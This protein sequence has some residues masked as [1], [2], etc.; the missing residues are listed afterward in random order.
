LKSLREEPAPDRDAW[1]KS[2]RE[3]ALR[4]GYEEP[5]PLVFRRGAAG[6][7]HA[8]ARKHEVAARW[9]DG[10]GA[11]EA[12]AFGGWP[13]NRRFLEAR[14]DDL[15]G[16]GVPGSG[17]LALAGAM[18]CGLLAWI[19]A[20]AV[21]FIFTVPLC[22]EAKS[23]WAAK[24]VMFEQR[25]ETSRAP[26]ASRVNAAPVAPA[27]FIPAAALAFFVAIPLCLVFALGEL[28]PAIS[29]WNLPALLTACIVFPMAL[30]SPGVAL[31]GL[32]AGVLTP[33]A[34]WA[35]YAGLRALLGSGR[36]PDRGK[37]WT[38]GIATAVVAAGIPALM[39]QGSDVYKGIRDR[40]LF[41]TRTGE[42][43]ATF[44]YRNTPLS[45]FALRPPEL[46]PRNSLLFAGPVP[47]GFPVTEY[48]FIVSVCSTKADFLKLA[49]GRGYTLLC[50]NEDGGPWVL[51]AAKE[52]K[53][54]DPMRS[55]EFMAASRGEL[56]KIFP[57]ASSEQFMDGDQLWKSGTA[58]VDMFNAALRA[59]NARADRRHS[60]RDVSRVANSLAI[61]LGPALLLGT[62][63]LW[64]AAGIAWLR[65]R[66]LRRAAG[67][68][69][70]LGFAMV[71]GTAFKVATSEGL[72]H[73]QL[74]RQIAE[75][76]GLRVAARV[77]VKKWTE[78]DT[79][80]AR[81]LPELK[82]AAESS[83]TGIR[84]LAMDALGAAGSRDAFLALG[85]YGL[86]DTSLLVRYRAA[87]AIG[88]DN[89]K[90]TR[91]ALLSNAQND[92]IYVAEAALESMLNGNPGP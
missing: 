56:E 8:L 71:A 19:V 12:S 90:R 7:F 18:A 64:V 58:R 11:W 55:L 57:E 83:D 75:F 45:A 2:A 48:R 24:Q 88:R 14:L 9:A 3:A 77:D 85:R 26:I 16:K 62:Y 81:A 74:R 53:Q 30:I 92:E 69:A 47:R 31:P 37:Q 87:D 15:Q 52:L 43:V 78:L 82:I 23:E 4:L 13:A 79:A 65:A 40:V 10:K 68:L 33:V 35:T 73:K 59:A 61:F 63:G 84:A 36:A 60:L 38:I 49:R 46:N 91:I 86:N 32:A 39:L 54:T 89:D 80:A 44:Y 51:E 66:G 42:A 22:R 72:L 70:F 29:R 6:A 17:L 41:G 21:M 67:A 28:L 25:Q 76:E 20:T 50:Y 34:A 1:E 5:S 27:A